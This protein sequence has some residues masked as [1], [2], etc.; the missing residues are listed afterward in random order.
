[1]SSLGTFYVVGPT[2]RDTA[3]TL[4]GTTQDQMEA[5]NA[6]AAPFQRN[7][8][9]IP[10]GKN[11]DG[12]LTAID[13]SHFNPYDMLIRP[14][15]AVLNSLDESNRLARGGIETGVQAAYQALNDFV[16]PFLGESIAFSAL[17]DVL[18]ENFL[19]VG[20][21]G[22]TKTGAKI[23]KDAEPLGK[24]IE[25]SFLHVLNQLGPT[26]LLPTRVPVGA[27][28]SE[29]ELSRLP[30]SLFAGKGDFGISEV[31]PSNGVRYTPH[32]EVFR[33]LTGLNIQTINPERITGF[34]ANEY[35]AARSEASTLFNDMVNR[36]FSDEE[37]YIN[38]YL[39]ANQARLKAFRQMASHMKH[40]RALGLSKRE[41]KKLLREEG[42]G[43]EELKFLERGQYLPYSPSKAKLDEA[44][45]KRHNVPKRTLKLLERDLYRLRIDP[46]RPDDTPEDAFDNPRDT[47]ILEML[48]QNA[49]RNA[50]RQEAAQKA[51]QKLTREIMSQ[52]PPVPAPPPQRP[53]P[54]PQSAVTPSALNPIVNPNPQDLALAQILAQR[55][56]RVG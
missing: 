23:Y 18:P 45:K 43:R 27:D 35:K 34:K 55:Q 7:A 11:E 26:N 28:F 52:V 2:L 16:D 10:L 49:R 25:R 12:H 44:K 22:R 51:T 1:M 40:L 19:A 56:R 53:D 46:D 32:T 37:D 48:Q 3:M 54:G 36:E 14:F 50:E 13:Y 8:T 4:T 39:A 42:V 29:V 38:G 15:E 47:S 30:R 5:M 24:K 17:Y 41:L 21:G 33:A 9:F 20:R 31:N 6:L